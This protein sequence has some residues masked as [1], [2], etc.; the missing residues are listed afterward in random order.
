[1][2]DV[3][4]G[5]DFSGFLKVSVSDNEQSAKV[6]D[7]ATRLLAGIPGGIEKA[8]Q[9]AL[10]RAATSGRSGAAREVGKLYH[11]KAA[12]FK[13]YTNTYQHIRRAGDEISVGIQFRGYHIPLIR[14]NSRFT[15][16]GRIKVQVS[17]SSSPEEFKH[18]FRA[19]MAS[20]HIGLFERAGKNRLPI[21]QK[22]G[23]SVPQMMGANPTLAPA[24]GDKVRKTF[25]ERM[26]HEILAILNG[27]RT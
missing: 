7:N 6:L 10:T 22:F 9:S 4:S 13:K 16:S 12:D 20:G 15:S 26:D 23:P 14:F 18:V 5:S 3:Y 19:E 25:E 8:T 2:S 24:I 1:M 11:L 27:W 21:E 17:R